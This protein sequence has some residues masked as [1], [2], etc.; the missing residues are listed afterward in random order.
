MA[1]KSRRRSRKGFVALPFN[2]SLAL[3]TLSNGAVL[4]VDIFGGNFTEDFYAISVDMVAS[5]RAATAGEGPIGI[6]FAHS[7]YSDAQI[8]EALAPVLLGPGNKIE[9]ERARRA[10]RRHGMLPGLLTEETM[11]DGLPKR[12]TLK[13]LVSSGKALSVWGENQ[14]G[15][16]LAGGAILELQGTA[17]GRW[18]I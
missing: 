4:S 8:A 12:T 16:A 14:S 5:I 15:A 2:T 10:V 1:H 7:D 3:S 13:F 18:L 9:Q 17:Y 11:G 6:G